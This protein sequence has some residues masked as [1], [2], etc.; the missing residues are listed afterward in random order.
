MSDTTT[1]STDGRFISRVFL[2]LGQTEALPPAERRMVWFINTVAWFGAV[3]LGTVTL[4]MFL[5]DAGW[6][7][8]LFGCKGAAFAIPLVLN[9]RGQHTAAGVILNVLA[10]VE[11]GSALYIAGF[12]SGA[13]VYYTLGA[14]VSFLCFRP[15]ERFWRWGFSISAL[16]AF[17]LVTYFQDALPPRMEAIPPVVFQTLNATNVG[18]FLLV[19]VFGFTGMIDLGERALRSAREHMQAL[20]DLGAYRLER[21][22]GQ[23]GMGEVWT[24]SHRLLARPAAIKLIRSDRLGGDA[25][26]VARFKREAQA[27]AE[28][29][30]PHTVELFDFGQTEEG[31]FYYV[32]ELLEGV[33]LD[34]YVKRFGKMAPARVVSILQQACLSLGEAHGAGLVHP[35]VKPANMFLCRL[36]GQHDFV[37]V[38]DFGLVKATMGHAP[39]DEAPAMP[40]LDDPDAPLHDTMPTPRAE[41]THA[42]A[43]I[44]TPAFMAPEQARGL[45]TDARS[46]VYALGCVAYWLLTGRAPFEAPNMRAMVYAHLF[47]TPAGLAEADVDMPAELEALVMQCLAKEP[48]DR[49][50]EADE[51]HTTLKILTESMPWRPADSERWWHEHKPER[52]ASEPTATSAPPPMSVTIDVHRLA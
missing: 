16:V 18:L 25:S 20:D 13:A 21:R 36:G 32:M 41:L 27:T 31:T 9:R 47:E 23:G 10:Q 8:V 35:D 38:L 12:E 34:A 50:Q 6:L 43:L 1:T 30:S 24:A 7:T 19:I 52:T 40:E 2:N 42:A 5:S 22:I 26:V 49:P 14:P 48:G 11:T 44:G 39:L 51:L 15:T 46:D 3:V 45:D 37:K 29:R 33:D 17:P 4:G 28:L